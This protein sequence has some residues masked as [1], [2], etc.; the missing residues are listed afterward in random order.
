LFG[1]ASAYISKGL[2]YNQI[3]LTLIRTTSGSS[4]DWIGSI[5]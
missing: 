3:K 2:P 5:P 4:L 1:D